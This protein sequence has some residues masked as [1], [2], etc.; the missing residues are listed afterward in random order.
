M[1]ILY[2]VLHY[3]DIRQEKILILLHE[4]CSALYFIQLTRKNLFCNHRLVKQRIFL[5]IK[6][7][8]SVKEN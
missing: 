4:K 7:L 6:L 2:I 3:F 5:D 1:L 8:M